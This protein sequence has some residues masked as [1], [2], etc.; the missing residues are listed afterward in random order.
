IGYWIVN[1]WIGFIVVSTS[2]RLSL[3][4]AFR[5][6]VPFWFALA[7]GVAIGSLPLALVLNV[8]SARFWP[9]NHGQFTPLLVQYGNALVLAEPVSFAYYFLVD[10]AWRSALSGPAAPRAA[11]AEPRPSVGGGFLDRLPPRLGRDL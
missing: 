3:L 10:R 7:G 9:G 8:F 6:D 1:M 11:S 2:V 4:A 5:L